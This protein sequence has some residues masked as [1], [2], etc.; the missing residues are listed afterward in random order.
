MEI[1]PILNKTKLCHT[2]NGRSYLRT[3]KQDNGRH[4]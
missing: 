3:C 2:K 4:K 1:S